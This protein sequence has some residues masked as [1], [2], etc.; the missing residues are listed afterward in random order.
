MASD[1]PIVY[2]VLPFH[3]FPMMAFS[4]YPG[5]V[6]HRSYDGGG[7]AMQALSITTGPCELVA[8][9]ASS[10]AEVRRKQTPWWK[11]D[12]LLDGIAWTDYG[13]DPNTMFSAFESSEIDVN[14]ETSGDILSQAESIGLTNSEIQTANTVVARFNVGQAPL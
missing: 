8:W 5:L 12:F 6:M 11:G 14:H 2:A 3:R 9:D 13:T 7:D 4:S 10:R 1:E